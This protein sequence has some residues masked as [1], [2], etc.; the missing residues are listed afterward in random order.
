[1]HFAGCRC[2]LAKCASAK[3]SS[4]VDTHTDAHICTHRATETPAIMCVYIREHSFE[5]TIVRF[6]ARN[7]IQARARIYVYARRPDFIG[8][9]KL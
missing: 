5:R 2:A 8:P 9:N 6:R 3:F 4:R 1:M 7:F